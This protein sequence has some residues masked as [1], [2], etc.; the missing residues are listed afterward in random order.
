MAITLR[1]IENGEERLH[2]IHN[3]ETIIRLGRHSQCDVVLDH[4]KKAS[5]QHCQIEKQPDGHYAIADLESSN[6]TQVNGKTIKRQVLELGDKINVGDTVIYFGAPAPVKKVPVRPASSVVAIGAAGRPVSG[7]RVTSSA[8]NG[9]ERAE[10]AASRAMSRRSGFAQTLITAA[11]VMFVLGLGGVVIWRSM[12]QENAAPTGPGQSSDTSLANRLNEATLES[13]KADLRRQL[14]SATS[15]DERR[16]RLENLV[17]KY[18]GTEAEEF[19]RKEYAN[20]FEG[21]GAAMEREV[22]S[23]VKAANEICRQYRFGDAFRVLSVFREEHQNAMYKPEKWAPALDAAIENVKQDAKRYFEGSVVYEANEKIDAGDLEAAKLIYSNAIEVNFGG[24]RLIRQDCEARIGT[25]DA[26]LMARKSGQKTEEEAQLKKARETS[27][28][29]IPKPTAQPNQPQPGQP[30]G[31]Q[32]IPGVSRGDEEIMIQKLHAKFIDACNRANGQSL[33]T[34]KLRMEGND[35]PIAGANEAKGMRLLFAGSEGTLPWTRILPEALLSGYLDIARKTLDDMWAIAYFC[36]RNGFKEQAE[37]IMWDMF[38]KDSSQKPQIDQFLARLKSVEMPEGG[39]I[40]FKGKFITPAEKEAME[41]A[42][43]VEELLDEIARLAGQSGE[44]RQAQLD[45]AVKQIQ[46]FGPEAQAKAVEVIMQKKERMMKQLAA[47]GFGGNSALDIL[48][49][50][51]DEARKKAL[52]TIFDKTIYPDENHGAVGQPKVDD[53]VNKVKELWANPS[54]AIEKVDPSVA[55][56]VDQIKDLLDLAKKVDPGNEVL[57]GDE[58]DKFLDWVK[59]LANKKMNIQNYSKDGGE[60]QRYG[61]YEQIEKDNNEGKSEATASERQHVSIVNAYRN[62][63]GKRA[64]RINSKLT[65]AARSHS[66]YLKSSNQFAHDVPGHPDGASPQDRARK[67]GYSG[68][69]GENIAMA[70]RGHSPQSS[71]DAWYHSSGHHRNMLGNWRVM[72]AGDG[73]THWTQMFGPS[74]D[75]SEPKAPGNGR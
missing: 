15:L 48:K 1:I 45:N 32:P 35:R 70:G 47:M 12:N 27:I 6:G 68:G 38:Q 49:K 9:T 75:G 74:E 42:A 54:A 24:M 3:H 19:I 22:E 50:Q 33:M 57:K 14:D 58:Q 55:K 20:F 56:K 8:S 71:F 25:I 2:E 69:V 60:Q 59:S 34:G 29:R 61:E 5:R 4:E 21:L 39:F 66:N 44:S 11:I 37:A 53:A 62:M 28:A 40:A 65:T 36:L 51:L 41:A 18:K 73:G 31:A 72:G 30:G 67:A 64:L 63:L 46:G 43:K 17:A 10:R 7:V 23:Q 52:E 26:V 16:K 13:A